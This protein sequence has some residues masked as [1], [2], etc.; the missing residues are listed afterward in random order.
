M[1]LGENFERP[2]GSRIG[3]H[4]TVP[5]DREKILQTAQK[6]IEKRRFDKAIIEY[7]KIVQED[8]NDARI[9]LKIGDLQ[10]RSEAFEAAIATYER[11]GR[12]YSSQGFAVKAIAVYKQIREI[13]RKHVP[14]LADQYGHIIPQLA[15]LYQELGLTGDALSAYDEYAT[16]LQRGGRDRDAAEIFRKIVEINGSNP[17][18]RLRLAEALLRQGE[19]DAAIEQFSFAAETLLGM[20]R[21]DDA[22]KVYERILY[23][24]PDPA[25]ARQAAQ[26]YLQR[27]QADDGM[28]ALAKLQV[29]FQA[30]N[31]DLDTLD[32]LARA[33]SAIGQRPKAIEV[34]KEIV[35][36]ARDK[37]N[38]A[39]ARKTLEELVTEAPNDDAIR[40]MAKSVLA[41]DG[42]KVRAQAAPERRAA[43]M[44]PPAKPVDDAVIEVSEEV[45]EVPPSADYGFDG[46]EPSLEEI[47]PLSVSVVDQAPAEDQQPPHS[48]RHVVVNDALEAAED[49]GAAQSFD[50]EAHAQQVLMTAEAFRN[51]RLYAKAIETLQ[52]GL[53]LAPGSVELR[54]GLKET[55]VEAGYR[56]QAV[57]ELLTIAGIHVESLRGQQAAQALG[58]VLELDPSNL[59]ARDMLMDLGYQPPGDV[60]D[61]SEVP[62]FDVH[63]L[64]ADAVREAMP[65]QQPSQAYEDQPAPMVGPQE[66]SALP[67]YDLE[68]INPSYAMSSVPST[69]R[70]QLPSLLMADDPFAALDAPAIDEP[71]Y[72]GE[73]GAPLPSF[74]LLDEERAAPRLIPIPDEPGTDKYDTYDELVEVG[75]A[76]EPI[77][78]GH[79]TDQGQLAAPL[80]GTRGFQGGDSLEDAL[81]EAE[82]FTSRGL[83]DDAL[84]I[85]Q[86]QLQKFPNH[87]LLLER[88]REVREAASAAAGSGELAVASGGEFPA[89]ET[90]DHAFDIAASL[91]VLDGGPATSVG[92][93]Y[94]GN[95]DVEEVFAKFKEGVKAQVSESDSATHYDLGV[96]YKEMGLHRDA[97]AEFEMAARDPARECVAWSMIGMVHLE[98]AELDAAVEAFIRGLHA[99]QKSAEQENALY[100]ELGAIYDNRGNA[101]EA[102]YY[103]EKVGRRDPGFRDVAQRIRALKG[104]AVRTRQN[105]SGEDEFDRAFDDLFTGSKM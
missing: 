92:Q 67:S 77:L 12:Y 5:I 44:P 59:R 15:Q 68:E 90:E 14:T 57:A 42:D 56:D 94:A 101:R 37:G 83:F 54:E 32:L 20:G 81:D 11:V 4:S 86:E 29:C 38:Q 30:D 64:E 7:Q 16:L 105:V 98:L 6:F 66:S 89:E 25:L 34:R 84:A 102:L 60:D 63:E 33:F 53:E 85:I 51:H 1:D 2:V 75:P 9:L 27:G 35:R 100:F 96:A 47:E 8:P 99:E 13:I 95:V 36:I 31:R 23:Q 52:I 48:I 93:P 70:H 58:E 21:T 104:S 40:A 49:L 91:D 72:E 50:A 17:L 61:T 80:A 41:P 97:I 78:L 79:A 39:L 76:E 73:R 22:L 55:F 3:V 45:I 69:G 88:V 65:A 46:S 43:V 18:A 62:P 103:F 82:F 19:N 24:K 26:M 87:P 71:F 74:P 10:A 28:M